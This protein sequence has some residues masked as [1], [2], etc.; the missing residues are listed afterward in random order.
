[1]GRGRVAGKETRARVLAEAQYV[2]VNHSMPSV[3]K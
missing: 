2:I 1:M 3:R